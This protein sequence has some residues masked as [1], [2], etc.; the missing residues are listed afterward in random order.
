MGVRR[1]SQAAQFG[2]QPGDFVT[3]L[4]NEPVATLDTYRD[5]LMSSPGRV[6]LLVRRGAFNYYFGF[7]F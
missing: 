2:L 3:R 1:G 7:R 5:G 4:N 6:L